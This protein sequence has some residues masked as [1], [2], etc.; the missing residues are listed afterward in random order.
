MATKVSSDISTNVNITARK[1]DSFYLEATL[2]NEDD[3]IFNLTSYTLT[4]LE[5]KKVSG[6]LV[7]KFTNS[8]NSAT[9]TTE[10]L[11]CATISTDTTNGIIK[12]DVP[13]TTTLTG[14]TA[15]TNMNL[16]VGSYDYTLKISSSTELHTVMHG[17][18][19]IVD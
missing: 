10:T 1:N 6:T 11:K 7:K 8:G 5:I 2:T 4:Q 13:Y 15:F 16:L 19:K 3:T 14:G 17:K 18:F 12:I 9:E